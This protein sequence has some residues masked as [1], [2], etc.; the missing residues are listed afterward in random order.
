MTISDQRWGLQAVQ[1][2]QAL[3]ISWSQQIVPEW[4]FAYKLLR[5]STMRS[6]KLYKDMYSYAQ[7][8]PPSCTLLRQL[9]VAASL[10]YRDSMRCCQ[11]RLHSPSVAILSQSELHMFVNT[12]RSRQAF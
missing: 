1:N 9:S 7:R 6:I 10:H 5:S 3:L 8:C 12:A 2:A 11:R 4:R